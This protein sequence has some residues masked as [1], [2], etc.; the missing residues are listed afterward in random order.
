MHAVIFDIDGTL[1]ET[2]EV[3]TTCYLRATRNLLEQNG[4]DHN[5]NNYPHA[6]DP[7]VLEELYRR[8]RGSP[9]TDREQATFE[10]HFL[11]LLAA[12]PDEAYR[13]VPGA[14]D[15]LRHMR[16]TG[17]AVGIATGCW[18]S[19][20]RL[21]LQRAGIPFEGLPLASASEAVSRSEIMCIAHSHLL[22]KFAQTSFERVLYFGDAPWDV[23]ATSQLGWELVGIGSNIRALQELKV[24]HTFADYL[25][26]DAILNAANL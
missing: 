24:A 12:Q 22:E 6:T 4:I 17:H 18:Q 26:G 5:W 13:A 15:F 19:S 16:D 1:T 2:N 21:K 10:E 8:H 23:R 14:G 9:P 20:A 11:A 7:G 3:D 25:D